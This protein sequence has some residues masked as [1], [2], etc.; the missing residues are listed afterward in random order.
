MK[1]AFSLL[2]SM[3]LVFS[4][5]SLGSLTVYATSNGENDIVVPNDKDEN[6]ALNNEDEAV[7]SNDEDD[8]KAAGENEDGNGT[9]SDKEL[10]DNKDKSEMPNHEDEV[11]ATSEHEKEFITRSM[12]NGVAITGYN[13]SSKDIVIPNEID[14]QPVVVIDDQAFHN[15]QLTSV[16]LPSSLT[17]I[18]R[19]AF[20]DNFL[21]IVKIPEGVTTIEEGAFYANQLKTVELP[22]SVTKIGSYAFAHNHLKH[23]EVP[24]SLTTVETSVFSYNQLT[25]VEIPEGVTTIKWDAFIY[26]QL[27]SVKIPE[28]VT[29]I[30]PYAFDHNELTSAELPSS[31]TTIGY[32]AFSYNQLRDIKIPSNVKSIAS[33]AFRYN[34]LRNVEIQL[35]VTTIGSFAFA[36]NQ[37]TNLEIEPSVTTIGTHAFADN[38]L[39]NLVIPSSVTTIEWS[40]F[41]NNQL[42][43][44]KLP[45]NIKTI[46][47]TAFNNNQLTEVEIPS[48]V[49]T[50]GPHAFAKN[51]LT[52]IEIPSSVTTIEYGA[53]YKNRLT[54]VVL[55]SSLTKIDDAAFEY[56]QLTSVEIPSSITSIAYSLFANNQIKSVEIPSSITVIGPY[57]FENNRLTNVEIPSSVIKIG[58]DAFNF[59][60]FDFV[61]F[62]GT[63][64]INNSSFESQLKRDEKDKTFGGWFEDKDY[65]IEWNKS[66][67][68]PMTIYAKWNSSED[69]SGEV[70][71]KYFVNFNSN[72]GS[73][74]P[75]EEVLEGELLQVPTVPVKKDYTFAGWYKDTEL[76]TSWDF[77]KDAVTEN[78]TL[79]AKWSKD[80]TSEGGSGEATSSYIITFDSNGGSKV[81]SKEVSKGEL[82]QAPTTPVKEDHTFAGWYKDEKLTEKWDFDHDV[83]TNNEVLYAEWTKYNS[84]NGGSGQGS[85]SYIVTF[86]TN[87][88][89]EVPSQ[90]VA[91]KASMQAPSNPM[92]EGY[93]FAGWYKDEELTESWDFKKDVVTKDLTLYARWTQESNGCNIIFKDIDNNWAKEMIEEIAKRCIIKGY[94]D[95]TFR[96]NDMIQRQHVVLMID[97]ALQLTPI[98]GAVSFS[99]VPKSHVYY[100][101]ITR[102]QR[103]GIVDGSNGEFRPNAYITR[104]QMA[105]ILVLA[106]DLTPE[107]NSTFKDVDSSHWAS[108]YIATLA[109]HNIALGDENGN[110][111]PNENLTRAQFTAFMY[112]ALGL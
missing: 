110:F 16:E 50:I 4:Q 24:S 39:T 88:G 21:T 46:A 32:N 68:Q 26:N 100:E 76:T 51:Q 90:T 63:P 103:A 49:T 102:L 97:R 80:N 57:A 106:F 19:S 6:K 3:L 33:N 15:R 81:S 23:V 54:S 30:E 17:T 109:D 71:T 47:H 2:V 89:S 38:K 52:S 11:I 25:S 65:T 41:S 77:K 28:G 55:P 79:Y 72:G 5:L 9:S 82:L 64:K 78:I 104:A 96:P 69:G 74:V 62:H 111:R 8:Y 101:Q 27:T 12:Y 18:G 58:E 36:N 70:Q 14:D 34:Q 35:G 31:L 48:S 7:T 94:P 108:G 45:S 66:V 95:G 83:V 10:V 44:L 73:E 84:S 98:R 107:G 112:R 75:S 87:G 1:K 91:Y 92:K 40:A 86:N 61:T 43:S 99:D 42:T 13:G 20:A 59:N 22:S 29:K 37:L 53:F 56:N 67:L 60:E 85:Q 105:K 93:T